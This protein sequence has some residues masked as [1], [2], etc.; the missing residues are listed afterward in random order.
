[1]RHLRQPALACLLAGACLSQAHADTVADFY[2]GPGREMKAIVRSEAGSGYDQ[3]SRLL[4][5]HLARHIPGNPNIVSI[6]MPGGGGITAANYMANV[7]P[8]DGTILSIVG[9]GL[10]ADQA[11]GLSPQL[12]ADV[13]AFNWIGNLQSSNQI[14]VVWHTSPT[15]TLDD[16]RRR[17]TSIGTTGAGSASAHYPAFYNNVLG[18]KF[19]LVFGYTGG[20]TINLAMERGEVEGRGTNTY[21][22]YLATTPHY[23]EQKLI[24]PIIQIG[25]RKDPVMPDV[26]LLLDQE[27]APENRAAVAF[28][29]K[30]ATMGRPF[31][32]T[33]G[34]PAER[35]AALRRA[36]DATMQDPAFIAEA[37]KL[38]EEIDPMK[39]ENLAQL[40]R[41]ILDAGPGVRKQV[42][43]LIKSD[44]GSR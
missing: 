36:F 17:E 27:V 10:I 26:P 1:M 33:P 32:T 2:S 4:S 41:E 34:V 38:K 5:R 6:N 16:A 18:T 14:L 44:S 40:V 23:I 21:A 42:L 8:K 37:Q 7:A 15:K 9:Q 20:P 24:R 12:K 39:G 11:L 30:A 25:I 31:A 19:K 43:D 28:M 29:S 22:S 3:L 35:V 13:S